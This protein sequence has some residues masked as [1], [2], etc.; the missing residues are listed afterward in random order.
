MFSLNVRTSLLHKYVCHED[1]GCEQQLLISV[2]VTATKVF[3]LL[4]S[5]KKEKDIQADQ[6]THLCTITGSRYY[7]FWV[8]LSNVLIVV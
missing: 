4:L 5:K 2:P 6:I 3:Q 1:S 7:F 8:L